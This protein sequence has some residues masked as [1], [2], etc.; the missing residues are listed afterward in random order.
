[1]P[2]IYL[3]L[4]N[5]LSQWQRSDFVIDGVKYNCGE[6]WMMA[7]KARL[8]KDDETLKK[9]MA[10][11][12]ALNHSGD[13][14]YKEWTDY[15]REQKRLGREVKNFNVDDWSKIAQEVVYKGNYAKFSQNEE[16]WKFLDG[17]GDKILA[18]ANPKDPVWGIALK[19]DDP[20]A[21]D[22]KQWKGTNWLGVALMRVR[23]Q[24]RKEQADAAK[25]IAHLSDGALQATADAFKEQRLAHEQDD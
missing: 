10:V 9:I 20:R 8:F 2:E 11:D 15:P 7:E 6:Q 21:Q 5:K 19:R 12:P 23:E 3:F 17:T 4:T 18:E 13:S 14:P 22:Q 24:I 16:F 25:A 1:M